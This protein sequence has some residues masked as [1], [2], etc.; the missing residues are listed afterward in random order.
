MS[1]VAPSIQPTSDDV[2]TG[3][4]D[5][6]R[7]DLPQQRRHSEPAAGNSEQIK[8]FVKNLSGA[9]ISEVERTIEELSKVRDMLR[10]EAE[11]VVRE[12]NAYNSLAQ[13]ATSSMKV[14]SEGLSQWQANGKNTNR[15]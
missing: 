15:R 13:A 11:R 6:V 8:S 7:R 2:Q 10:S 1:I 4:R 3:L 9:T 14:I 12:V 5:L